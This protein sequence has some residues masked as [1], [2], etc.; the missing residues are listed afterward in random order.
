MR[1]ACPSS[2]TAPLNNLLFGWPETLGYMLAG[3]A[4]LRSGLL[5]GAW[6]RAAYRRGLWIGFGIGGAGT[7]LIG[8]WVWYQAFTIPAVTSGAVA[9]TT[10]FRPLM[11]VGWI[12]GIVLLMRPGG[13][14]TRRIAAAGRMAFSNYLGTSL[15]CTT[16]FYGYGLGWYGHLTRAGLMPVVLAVWAIMVLWSEPWLRRFRYGPL[17]WLWRSLSRGRI[18]PLLGGALPAAERPID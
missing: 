8:W 2:Q 3:M 4:A 14:L 7:A 1:R 15:I 18:Q 5:T 10:L 16:L 9:A 17:E 11:I 12:S 13:V 6:S